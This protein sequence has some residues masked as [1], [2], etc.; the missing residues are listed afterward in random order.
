MQRQSGTAAKT[1]GVRSGYLLLPEADFPLQKNGIGKSEHW[2]IGS[3]DACFGSSCL[4]ML[5]TSKAYNL[6]KNNTFTGQMPEGTLKAFM[7]SARI[8]KDK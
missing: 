1:R 7:F 8:N 6:D 3:K 2:I 4:E 5:S